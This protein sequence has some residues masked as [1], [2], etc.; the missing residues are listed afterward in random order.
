MCGPSLLVPELKNIVLEGWS[1]AEVALHLWNAVFIR[2]TQVVFIEHTA[3]DEVRVLDAQNLILEQ[4]GID[5][6]VAIILG[7]LFAARGL[8]SALVCVLGEDLELRAKIMME[9][10][11]GFPLRNEPI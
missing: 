7:G 11:A 8:L 2:V 1:Q 6:F 9:I 4:G 5:V 3:I 10:V